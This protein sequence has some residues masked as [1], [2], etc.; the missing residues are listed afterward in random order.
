MESVHRAVFLKFTHLRIKFY[1]RIASF[2]STIFE[3]KNSEFPL[4]HVR[5]ELDVRSYY[6]LT[7]NPF[8][9]AQQEFASHYHIETL[10]LEEK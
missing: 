2:E 8:E 6:W 3:Q 5:V 4:R 9:N 1:E 7:L 10:S